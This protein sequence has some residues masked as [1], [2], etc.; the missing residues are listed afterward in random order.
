M[1]KEDPLPTEKD[2]ER[3]KDEKAADAKK[4][5]APAKEAKIQLEDNEAGLELMANGT[6]E[7]FPLRG[8]P[9]TVPET[10]ARGTVNMV[11]PN[12]K[13]AKIDR[14]VD[15]NPDRSRQEWFDTRTKSRE[16]AAE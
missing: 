4:G 12:G 16:I 3:S 7:T 2:D 14:K 10:W 5:A 6:P 13:V 8:N 1:V 15:N 9:K 11:D